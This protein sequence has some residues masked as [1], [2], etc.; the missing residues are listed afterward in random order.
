[1]TSSQHS[2]APDSHLVC[3]SLPDAAG[4]EVH[5]RLHA[6]ETNLSQ[7]GIWNLRQTTA[8]PN[9]AQATTQNHSTQAATGTHPRPLNPSRHKQPRATT[10]SKQSQATTGTFQP[11]QPLLTATSNLSTT[12]CIQP[13][14]S[15]PLPLPSSQLLQQQFCSSS[16]SPQV[17]KH[18]SK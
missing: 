7:N 14:H 11:K 4:L 9:H 2:C 13:R 6:H 16:R 8:H 10:Q 3:L 1:M 12:L 5:Q 17:E 15:Q 18:Y